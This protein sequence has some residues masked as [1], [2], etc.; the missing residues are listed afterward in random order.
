MGGGPSKIKTVNN[1]T[2]A[3]DFDLEKTAELL[4]KKVSDVV[5]SNARQCSQVNG[6]EQYIK[7]D[8]LNID[9]SG[10][11]VDINQLQEVAVNL[12]CVQIADTYN[13][14]Q[15]KIVSEI[16]DNIEVKSDTTVLDKMLAGV[17]Y[18]GADETN[19]NILNTT[20]LK[21]KNV[22]QN[23][24]E[25]KF[26][27]SNLDSCIAKVENDQSQ[28]YKNANISNGGQ[29]IIGQ[30]QAVKQMTDCLQESKVMNGVIT[31]IAN[32]LQVDISS[33]NTTNTGKKI[34]EPSIFQNYWTWICICCI[35]LVCVMGI[36]MIVLIYKGGNIIEEN[37]ELIQNAKLFAGGGI[38]D[39]VK[40]LF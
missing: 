4:N 2:I 6:N 17:K 24:F 27:S 8:N 12:K 22:V 18:T 13:S 32:K 30:T 37:P 29:L 25:D 33:N 19:T 16:A 21:L 35:C 7:F 3:N 5:V 34:E 28:V 10:S 9:G 1:T 31:D 23:V 14:V 26:K 20:K 40:S 15:N 39:K 11:K 38:I 36:V